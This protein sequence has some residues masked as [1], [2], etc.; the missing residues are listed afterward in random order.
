MTV[1]LCAVHRIFKHMSLQ[2]EQHRSSASPT[3]QA[4]ESL[5]LLAEPSYRVLC[6]NAQLKMHCK[7]AHR[8]CTTD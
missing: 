8:D 2:G 4:E 7:T 3:L 1:L 6:T 5:Q